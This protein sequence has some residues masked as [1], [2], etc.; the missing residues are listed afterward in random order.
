VFGHHHLLL[1]CVGV[2][3]VTSTEELILNYNMTEFTLNSSPK[4]KVVRLTIKKEGN[5]LRAYE[6]ADSRRVIVRA[7]PASK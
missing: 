2:P 5:F 3:V 7:K 6:I 4:D 1:R